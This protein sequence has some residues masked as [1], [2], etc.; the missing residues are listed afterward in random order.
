MSF[1]PCFAAA[2]LVTLSLATLQAEPRC[3]GNV[4]SLSLRPVQGVLIVVRVE[5]NH[6]GPY[7][8][9]VDT[10]S[11]F[12]SI[13]PA[14]A[15]K[16]HLNIEGTTGVSGVLTHSRS[17]YGYLD[18]IEAGD[19]SVPNVLAVIQDISEFQAA[20][21]RIRGILGQSFLSHFDLLIDNRQQIL[22]LDELSALAHAVRGEHIPLMPPRGSQDDLPFTRPMIVSARITTA[23]AIPVLLRLDSGSA[24]LV[25]Y[26]VPPR[27]LKASANPASFFKRVVNGAEQAFAV[28]PAQDIVLGSTPAHKVPFVVPMNAVGG[29]PS[30][31]EDGMLPTIAFAHVFISYSHHYAV[32]DPWLR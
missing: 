28:L 2:G 30:P 20:D 14:L 6:T 19:H 32:F 26:D 16:L 11:Q 7:D 17:G 24:A 21:P 3:P 31:R 12:T 29:G 23:A 13:D 8:F 22:C 27:L 1:V 15:A 25:L 9:M 10:G 5:I 4:S 18:L